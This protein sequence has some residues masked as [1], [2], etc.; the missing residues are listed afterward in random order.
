MSI[1]LQNGPVQAQK[2]GHQIRGVRGEQLWVLDGRA[3]SEGTHLSVRADSRQQSIG[4]IGRVAAASNM[5]HRAA[6]LADCP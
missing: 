3:Y 5:D 4:H 1:T 2:L 6:Y